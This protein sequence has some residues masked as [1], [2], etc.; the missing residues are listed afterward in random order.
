[1]KSAIHNYVR[2]CSTCQQAKP[3]RAKYPGLLQPLP[4]PPQAWHT[5]SLDFVEGLPRSGHANCILVVIDKF[6]KYS[7]FLPLLHPFTAAKVAN[8]FLDHIY[9]L[10]GLP[11]VLVSDRDRVFTSTFWQTLFQLSGTQLSM[12]SSYHPQT[13]GQTERLNQCLETFLRC[14]VHA[15]PTKWIHWLSVAEFWYNTSYQSSL[16]HTPFHVLYGYEP[17][18]FGISA[19]ATIPVQDLVEWLYERE[20]MTKLVRLHLT[21]AQERMKRQA[22]KKRSERVFEVGDSVYLKLQPYIQ[23]SVATRSNHKLS[24]KFFGLYDILERIGAVAYRLNLPANSSIH[25]VFH[26]SQLKRSLGR[27]PVL[28]HTLPR[29]GRAVQVPIRVLQHRMITRGGELISQIKVQWSDME[30][31]L[32]TWEDDKALRAR[33]PEAPAWGQAAFEGE[34]NV[35]TTRNN[36]K[37]SSATSGT[38]HMLTEAGSAARQRRPNPKY[39]V[40][41]W[42]V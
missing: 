35:S 38:E 42:A 20:L 39:T 13:D 10:H 37:T 2:S 19:E 32:S 16:G 6:S 24:F 41:M 17:K 40:P 26:V 9:K 29:D 8:V 4:V 31:A 21:R 15:C 22:D 30:E 11:T 25:P 18:H 23:S 36:R 34:R 5:V 1:M 3:D 33:F 28:I 12:S 14:F 7:H 27:D